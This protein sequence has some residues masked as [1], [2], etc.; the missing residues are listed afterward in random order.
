MMK[1]K[2]AVLVLALV[3][4]M[5]GCGGSGSSRAMEKKLAEGV[6]AGD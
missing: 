4:M 6:A 3:L 1:I 2:S 5:T